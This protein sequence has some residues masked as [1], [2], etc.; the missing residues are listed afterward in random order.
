[1][2]RRVGEGDY[3]ALNVFLAEDVGRLNAEKLRHML[4]EINTHYS[5]ATAGQVPSLVMIAVPQGTEKFVRDQIKLHF[6]IQ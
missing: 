1:M 2:D 3:I 6:N 5:L 4:R